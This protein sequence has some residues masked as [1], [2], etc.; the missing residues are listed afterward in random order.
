MRQDR[1]RSGARSDDGPEAGVSG[2]SYWQNSLKDSP[3]KTSLARPAQKP[4]WNP[5]DTYYGKF[6]RVAATADSPEH[7]NPVN[8]TFVAETTPGIATFRITLGISHAI[9]TA[10]K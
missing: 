4:V 5:N 10:W 7:S 2:L 8:P 3:T 1:G 6:R 9:A